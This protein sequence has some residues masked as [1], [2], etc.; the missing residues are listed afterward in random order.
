M[1]SASGVLVH[2]QQARHATPLLVHAAHQVPGPF[3][4]NHEHIDIG[5]RHHLPKVDVKPVGKGKGIA[6][7]EIGAN[8]GFVHSLL[9]FVV[10]QDHHDV[11]P[12]AGLGHIG[13]FQPF[14]LGLSAP[15]AIRA[16]AHHHLDATLRQV[17]R[18]RV[19]LT[20]VAND[21]HGLVREQVEIGVVVVEHL[22]KNSPS[23]RA[24]RLFDR[25]S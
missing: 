10:N 11:P 20:A 25:H 14:G 17:E 16:Q 24:L 4:R 8:I 9:D 12:L 21:G 7:F 22:H 6:R 23:L 5:R 13:D 15:L 2:G 1:R 18:M 3:G 19:A